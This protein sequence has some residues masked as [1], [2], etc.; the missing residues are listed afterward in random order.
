PD[1]PCCLLTI[2]L[3]AGA[4]SSSV[5][6]WRV[7]ASSLEEEGLRSKAA[8][9]L[10]SWAVSL[11]KRKIPKPT[12]TNSVQAMPT[13][14]KPAGTGDP[15]EVSSQRSSASSCDPGLGSPASAGFWGRV[16]DGTAG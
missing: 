5:R 7:L 14:I 3:T 15:E 8:A 10:V 6:S 4:A 11:D 12:T 1:S 16:S 13:A 2:G 9:F